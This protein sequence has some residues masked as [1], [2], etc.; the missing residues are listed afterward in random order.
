MKKEYFVE[1]LKMTGLVQKDILLIVKTVWA[2]PEQHHLL[3]PHQAKKSAP[4]MIRMTRANT[5][6]ILIH[7]PF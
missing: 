7:P 1:K 4:A 2:V 5:P 6:S 3:Q